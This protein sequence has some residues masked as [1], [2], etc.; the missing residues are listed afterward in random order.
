ML[1]E[2]M[3]G[4][5]HQEPCT[6]TWNTYSKLREHKILID[7]IKEYIKVYNL[8]MRTAIDLARGRAQ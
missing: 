3:T 1:Q 2:R 8:D 6:V 4:D 5:Y 7:S